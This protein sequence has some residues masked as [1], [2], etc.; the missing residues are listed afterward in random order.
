MVPERALE[1]RRHDRYQVQAAGILR[2]EGAA[3]N[4]FLVTLLD[5]SKEGFRSS[6]SKAFPTG[7]MV[8]LDCRGVKIKGEIRYAT[9]F[10]VDQ[11]YLGVAAKSAS[12][13]AISQAGELDLT[14]LFR[15]SA[16]RAR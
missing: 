5:V 11:Y 14:L 2:V 15:K 4:V 12:G 9:S 10:G 6:C 13:G 16:L 8:E 1:N 3:G 7:T